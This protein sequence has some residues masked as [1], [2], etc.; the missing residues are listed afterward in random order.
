MNAMKLKLK[1]LIG[2][3]TVVPAAG[4]GQVDFEHATNQ[5]QDVL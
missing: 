5:S 1:V 4:A 3:G 2:I